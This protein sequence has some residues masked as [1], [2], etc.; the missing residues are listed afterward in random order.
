MSLL[1]PGTRASVFR[2]CDSVIIVILLVTTSLHTVDTFGGI[3]SQGQPRFVSYP[4]KRTATSTR[5]CCWWREMR[6]P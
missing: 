6:W 4:N 1:S 3:T 2:L 5:Q